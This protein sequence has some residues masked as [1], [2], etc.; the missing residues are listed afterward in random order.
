MTNEFEKAKAKA[1]VLDA[2]YRQACQDIRDFLADK[3]TGPM[4][5]TPDYVKAMPEFQR[6]KAA[7]ETAFQDLRYFNAWYTKTFKNEIRQK[8]AR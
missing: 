4:G 5:L 7:K 1:D 8:H 3:P 6:L 2:R